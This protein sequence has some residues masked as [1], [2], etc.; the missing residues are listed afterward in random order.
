L[1]HKTSIGTRT[2]LFTNTNFPHPPQA[3]ATTQFAPRVKSRS[4]VLLLNVRTSEAT[5]IKGTRALDRL[6]VHRQ[7]NEVI[8]PS[9]RKDEILRISLETGNV[10]SVP[11]PFNATLFDL[12]QSPGGTHLIAIDQKKCVHCIDCLDWSIVWSTSLKK[13]LGRDHM[14]VGQYSGDGTL[15]GGGGDGLR[16]LLHARY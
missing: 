6:V 3:A 9:Q 11:L 10:T 16:S 15:I 5:Q 2:P 7:S 1:N 4:R 12:K 14:G 13:V 8:V